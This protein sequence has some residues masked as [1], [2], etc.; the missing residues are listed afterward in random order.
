MKTLIERL[1]DPYSRYLEKPS[2]SVRYS[3]F[4]G[5]SV[6]A[7]FTVAR[8]LRLSKAS[9]RRSLHATK[10]ME[11]LKTAGQI[12]ASAFASTFCMRQLYS[13]DR[14]IAMIPAAL[15][16][17]YAGCKL[18]PHLFPIE[19]AEV[20]ISQQS[21]KDAH[22]QVGDQILA[23]NGKKVLQLPL[24]KVQKLLNDGDVGDIVKVTVGRAGG[25][26]VK[27][28]PQHLSNPNISA[29]TMRFLQPRRD[30]LLWWRQADTLARE[31]SAP[32]LPNCNSPAGT[33]KEVDIE[34]TRQY[35]LAASSVRNST[36]PKCGPGM[37]YISISEFNDQTYHDVCDA[38]KDLKERI[39]ST[40]NSSLRGLVFDL[41]GNPGG[42]IAP[43]LDISAL[44]LPK[45]KVLTQLASHGR[46]VKYYS[47][48]RLA[49]LTTAL[50]L[51]VDAQTASASEILVEALCDNG[52]A[53]SMGTRTVGKNVAQV[54]QNALFLIYHPVTVFFMVFTRKQ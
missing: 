22:V 18:Y 31:V 12:I 46:T 43:A 44:F 40:Q 38:I 52:R 19:V 47:K 2:M 13:F 49:D 14:R 25:N 50:L 26:F 9:I 34:L 37:G 28:S 4:R 51:L 32:S 1:D 20:E 45:G 54:K 29:P 7:G 10:N 42:P 24:R 6:S 21:R 39:F 23:I 3:K 5:I 17:F 53:T 36:L 30:G 35:V 33:W 15:S 27:V 41:R 16:V 48:N 11:T 8:K